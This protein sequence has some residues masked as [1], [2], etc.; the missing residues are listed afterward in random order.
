MSFPAQ[1]PDAHCPADKSATHATIADCAAART[2]VVV[3]DFHAPFTLYADTQA[4]P[5][6]SAPSLAVIDPGMG[7]LRSVCRAWQAA[8]ANVRTARTPQA[9]SA[10]GKEPDALIF[11]G[12]GGMP[13][14]M[15]ALAATG[16][17]D[18]IRGW[19]NENRPFFGICLGM[20][21]LFEHSEE[22]NCKGLGILP[23]R[24]RRFSLPAEF[25]IPHMGWN[26]VSFSPLQGASAAA[27]EGL[28]ASGESFYFVH[29]YYVSTEKT[30][31]IWGQT[32]Y[33]GRFVS[34]IAHGN[35][36]ATQ[37]HPEKSQA[38]GLQMYHNYVK[39]LK[40]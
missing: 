12:Q 30:P 38:K 37:F 35:C 31:I 32:D 20:Q 18:F 5:L 17:D 6:D 1:L 39:Y 24:V 29:S 36:L 23:G 2:D 28:R 11:P 33:G 16:F 7:N 13:H 9:V 22:G 40:H 27:T 15:D 14:C 34:A 19:I 26:T 21:A 10:N 3:K 25:K 8:G 4:E